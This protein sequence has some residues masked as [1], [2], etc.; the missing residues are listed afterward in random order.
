MNATLRQRTKFAT[1]VERTFGD[2]TCM[3]CGRL[4]SAHNLLSGV[5]NRNHCPYCLASR[6]LDLFEAGDR[7]AACKAVMRAIGITVK[8][9][10]KKYASAAG[11]LMLIHLCQDCG[12]LS[13]NRLAAD[14]DPQLVM[15]LLEAGLEQDV[16]LR[17]R[18]QGIT[19][20]QPQDAAIVRRQ[21][22]GIGF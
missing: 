17:L 7:L 1:T 18:Q 5:Q 10:R 14:D 20:L 9:A 13:I 12:R 21:L 6:H 19:P 16:Y 15:G 8:A 2:F 11:E 22:F 4:V 3:N